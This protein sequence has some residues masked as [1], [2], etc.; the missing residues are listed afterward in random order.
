METEGKGFVVKDKRSFDDRGDLREETGE[1]RDAG[2]GAEAG[3]GD[4]PGEKSGDRK[5][6]PLP[7]VNFST[8]IMSLSSSALL[9]MGEIP[10][11]TTGQKTMDIRLAK[12][13]IDTI[14]MLKDKTRGNLD[15]EEQRFLDTMLADLRWRFVKASG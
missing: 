9:H 4:R 5:F 7:E 6:Q 14:S 1:P 15:D 2:A 10:D 3:T 12:H 11:P 8:L 13:T